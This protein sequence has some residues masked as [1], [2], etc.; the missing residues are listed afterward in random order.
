MATYPLM[1]D[2]TDVL[3]KRISDAQ[4]FVELGREEIV[5]GIEKKNEYT[6]RQGFEKLF[7]ALSSVYVAKIFNY[8]SYNSYPRNH[9][10]LEHELEYLNMSKEAHFFSQIKELMHGRIYY[11]GE[12]SSFRL[13]EQYI[14]SIEAEIKSCIQQITG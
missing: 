1:I 12:T 5:T 14:E 13:G 6:V 4:H 3:L 7:H 11:Q 9:D 8:T 10:A 2:S